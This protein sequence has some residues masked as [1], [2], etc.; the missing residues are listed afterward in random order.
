LTA[1]GLQRF[2]T[3]GS[4]RDPVAQTFRH[5]FQQTRNRFFVI[6]QQNVF[7]TLGEGFSSQVA[8]RLGA[9]IDPG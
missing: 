8:R 9:F 7:R 5:P 1:E 2:H 4:R 6:D 3:A